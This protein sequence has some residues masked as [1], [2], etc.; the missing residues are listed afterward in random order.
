MSA[1]RR[2]DTRREAD[3]PIRGRGLIDVVAHELRTPLAAILGYQELM[4]DGLYGPLPKGIDDAVHR[5]GRSA[6]QLLSLVDGLDLLDA[7][8]Q[9][10][11]VGAAAFDVSTV[12]EALAPGVQ[13]DATARGLTLAEIALKLGRSV[14][15]LSQVERGL[16]APSLAD[17]RA[18]AEL[19]GVPVSLFFAHDA[20]D[21]GER[22]VVVRAR[23]LRPGV[24]T[25]DK[26]P[27]AIAGKLAPCSRQI[28]ARMLDATGRDIS[29]P[30]Y[31]KIVQ[32]RRHRTE[33]IGLGGNSC[34]ENF[35]RTPVSRTVATPMLGIW[36]SIFLLR[37]P[38]RCRP[39]IRAARWPGP[40]PCRLRRTRS[41]RGL[42][43]CGSRGRDGSDAGST[44]S[45]SPHAHPQG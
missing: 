7:D 20:P 16:S 24:E 42:Q 39:R 5:I 28:Q 2:R 15:W 44:L 8:S 31:R 40:S 23:G 11:A 27:P 6:R 33:S 19:F 30:L 38:R 36:Y 22:G 26:L 17:L 41:R 45:V 32:P 37:I 4:A 34:G 14:G 43:A 21:A 1:D 12:F 10:P 25:K 3:E 9:E 35:H 18:F 29:A 13:E